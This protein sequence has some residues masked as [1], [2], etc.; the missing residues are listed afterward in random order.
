M[1]VKNIA[2]LAV[3][4]G[5]SVI[6][7]TAS[8]ISRTS[9][10]IPPAP[11]P[12]RR[13]LRPS[14]SALHRRGRLSLLRRPCRRPPLRGRQPPLRTPLPPRH[15]NLPSA[16][17]TP[18]SPAPPASPPSSTASPITPTSPFSRAR[19]TAPSRASVT[20]S[21][22]TQEMNAVA[23]PDAEDRYVH[24]SSAPISICPT[25]RP[26]AR[27]PDRT[28]ADPSSSRLSRLTSSAPPSPSPPPPR[29]QAPYLTAAPASTLPAL[30]PPRPR[31]TPALQPQAR[32]SPPSPRSPLR[33][34]TQRLTD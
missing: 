25:R 9:R 17:G 7:R 4:A 11:P 10:A 5:L 30:L 8:E 29:L 18:S 33:P 2:F 19:A 14:R 26:R 23:V 32:L 20:P 27:P 24:A 31:G 22:A 16:T 12:A 21:P 28:L 6:F 34:L 3:Q 15:D 13:L 1:I